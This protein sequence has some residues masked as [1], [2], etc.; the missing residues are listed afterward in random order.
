M[1]VYKEENR[2]V[3]DSPYNTLFLEEA[4]RLGGRFRPNSK[5]WT[6]DVRDE[7]RVKEMLLRVYGTDGIKED[8]C[9]LRIEWKADES[10]GKGP[11]IAHGRK[12]ASAWGRDSGAK[13]GDGVILLSGSFHSGGSMKN[14]ETRV[15]E[16]TVVL[17]RDF[18]RKEAEA[19]TVKE[20]SCRVYSI[21]EEI[22]NNITKLKEEKER[23]E[24]RLKEINEILKA[25]EESRQFIV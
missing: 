14:W 1:K 22:D 17:V 16:G 4:K 10:V 11:I 13:L 6:F 19:R 9:T 18:P 8:F 7:E 12:I 21:Y 15:R 23:L 3:V 20:S 25:D 24:T 5:E 2:V